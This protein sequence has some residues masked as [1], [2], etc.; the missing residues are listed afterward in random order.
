MKK[1]LL[2]LA[3]LAASSGYAAPDKNFSN[4]TK[5]EINT[6]CMKLMD[7]EGVDK[8]D[9]KPLCR[10]ISE[11]V[12]KNAPNSYALQDGEYMQRAF[13]ICFRNSVQDL[14]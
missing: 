9:S 12:V 11:C 7:E 8:V 5:T 6:F 14:M 4:Q 1:S 10:K 13:L 2:L 3:I